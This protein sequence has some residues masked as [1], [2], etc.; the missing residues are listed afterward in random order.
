MK[1]VSDK[2]IASRSAFTFIFA[3]LVFAFWAFL[4]PYHLR[5][6]EEVQYFPY[7]FSHFVSY[8]KFPGGIVSY[9][10]E[11][12]VQFFYVSWLGAVIMALLMSLV[13]MQAW[14]LFRYFRKDADMAYYPLSF[15]PAV[16]LWAFLA[17]S[18]SMIS[19]VTAVLVSV[20]VWLA[21]SGSSM[22]GKAKTALLRLTSNWGNSSAASLEAE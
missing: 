2:G 16:C 17:G 7:L 6:H 20:G 14:R 10:S 9:I 15:V 21:V 8:L 5:Y 12:L 18:G 3:L 1:P 11:F 19:V 13:Q 22:C 4:F